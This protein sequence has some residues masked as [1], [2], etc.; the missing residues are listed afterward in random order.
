MD[1]RSSTPVAKLPFSSLKSDN[2]F[3]APGN[4]ARI[5]AI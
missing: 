5:A 3:S 2:A 4:P 1:A